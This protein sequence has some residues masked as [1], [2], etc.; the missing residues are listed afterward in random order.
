MSWSI[1]VPMGEQHRGER[2]L[3]EN[4]IDEACEDKRLLFCSSPDKGQ[5]ISNE[6]PS[7]ARR[8]SLFR[9]GAAYDYG[10][11]CSWAD[12]DVDYIFPGV[13]VNTQAMTAAARR[14]PLREITGS[15]VASA[16][17]AGLAATIIYCFKT[18]ALA[19]KIAWSQGNSRD[20]LPSILFTEKHVRNI[21]EFPA[22]KTALSKIGF[23]NDERF[24]Q[25]WDLFE[26]VNQILED[27][28]KT[29]EDKVETIVRMCANLVDWQREIRGF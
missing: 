9:I 23:I 13:K 14:E 19:G 3:F 11:R 15:G 7:D 26:P 1:P 21:A 5:F 16:L 4:A 18:S 29:H 27:P 25:V 22:M 2:E 6:Y 8:G 17:A 24:I 20:T 28:T 10:T 12:K